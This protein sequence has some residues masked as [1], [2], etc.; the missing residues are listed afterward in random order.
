M[1]AML[2]LSIGCATIIHGGGDQSVGISSSLN[3]AEVLVD[4]AHRGLTP[5]NVNLDR[6]KPHTIVVKKDGYEDSSATTSPAVSAWIA[7]NLLFGGLIGLAI[8][9]ISGGA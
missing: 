1:S 3:G 2:I 9:F 5:L 6:D 4:D 7:G 8:D